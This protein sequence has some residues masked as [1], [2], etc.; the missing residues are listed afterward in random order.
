MPPCW[1]LTLTVPMSLS[2]PRS[3]NRDPR[4][5]RKCLPTF[6]FLIRNIFHACPS[7]AFFSCHFAILFLDLD[8]FIQDSLW[9]FFFFCIVQLQ[10]SSLLSFLL[11]LVLTIKM[12]WRFLRLQTLLQERCWNKMAF[13]NYDKNFLRYCLDYNNTRHF[14]S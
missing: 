11:Y 1:Q 14:C 8:L 9:L 12:F 5:S 2:H 13:R 6:S 10:C 4:R 3:A 7:L